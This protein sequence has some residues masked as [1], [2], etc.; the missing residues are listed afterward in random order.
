MI[1]KRIL[2]VPSA[3]SPIGPYSAATEANG[4][5]FFSGQVGMDTDTGS[6]AAND[7]AGQARRA[8]QNI[9]AMLGDLGLGFD[10]VVKTSIFLAD[11]G[12]FPVVNEV[13]AEYFEG[14]N[15]ARSTFQAAGLPGGYLVE[16]EVIAAR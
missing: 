2:D 3:P 13:Y 11:I 1:P 14:A 5:V 9:G 12:D 16:I 10:D 8:M 15:P 4:F 6:P 7:V